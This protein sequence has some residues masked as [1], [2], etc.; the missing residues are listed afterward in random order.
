MLEPHERDPIEFRAEPRGRRIPVGRTA[1]AASRRPLLRE[2]G[3]E[4][5]RLARWLNQAIRYDSPFAT[6]AAMEP[7]ATV[8]FG[9][10]AAYLASCEKV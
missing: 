9:A 8:G 4:G 5:F 2:A 1:T 6:R 7:V 10:I 3:F